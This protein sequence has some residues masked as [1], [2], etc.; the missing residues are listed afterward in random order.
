MDIKSFKDFSFVKK[1]S[2]GIVGDIVA[3]IG[4]LKKINKESVN[5][6]F[7]TYVVDYIKKDY[8]AFEGRVSRRQFWMFFL[9]LFVIETILS[10]FGLSFLATLAFA[11][12]L[13]PLIGLSIRRLHDIDFSWWW[14]LLILTGIGIIVLL[15]IFTIPGDKTANQYGPT[16]K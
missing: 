1:L 9:F 10:L 6:A 8:V 13:V 14:L 12:V 4:N 5:Q 3:E 11:L 15:L 7:E 2:N 16:V